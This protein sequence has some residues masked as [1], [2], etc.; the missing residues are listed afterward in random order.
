MIAIIITGILV[1]ALRIGSAASS[2][3]SQS[4]LQRDCGPE[5]QV[6]ATGDAAS[7]RRPSSGDEA[8][9]PNPAALLEQGTTAEPAGDESLEGDED[10]MTA[11][12]RV[13]KQYVEL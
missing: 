1:P 12:N 11:L 5:G 4:A 7:L 3:D 9:R 8:P 2:A 10:A 13:H 6:D